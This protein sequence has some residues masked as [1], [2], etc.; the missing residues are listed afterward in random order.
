[1]KCNIGAEKETDYGLFFQWGDTVGYDEDSASEYSSTSTCPGYGDYTTWNNNNLTNNVL[2]T[3]VDAAYVHTNGKAKMPTLTQ[4][5][6]LINETNNEWT[7]ID[8][9]A[10]RKFTNKSDSS[11]YIFI[12]AAGFFYDGKRSSEGLGGNV[13]SSSLYTSNINNAYGLHLDDSS[14]GAGGGNRVYS[15]SVRGVK[16]DTV[17]LKVEYDINSKDSTVYGGNSTDVIM[18][19]YIVNAID[20][21]SDEISCTLNVE[22]NVV[23]ELCANN[24]STVLETD[25]IFP[26][27]ASVTINGSQVI[28][29]TVVNP[30]PICPSTYTKEGKTYSEGLM[31]YAHG[32]EDVTVEITD[33]KAPTGYVWE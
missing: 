1:M 27:K 11:K 17:V 19:A 32:E 4:C 21:I 3:S 22:G 23:Y 29:A 25:Y 20:S 8:G 9:V 12:P 6:E 15:F 13:W 24:G 30:R 10:G 5:K 31:M 2:N 33:K 14:V 16:N 26:I 28:T 7:T 18:N